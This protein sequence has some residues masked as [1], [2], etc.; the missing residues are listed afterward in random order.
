MGV[1]PAL[2][3]DVPLLRAG[4][5]WGS[6]LRDSE[7]ANS[8]MQ[9]LAQC[10]IELW[11]DGQNMHPKLLFQT[12]GTFVTLMARAKQV[13]DPPRWME[14]FH[15][16][17][18]RF[19]QL[20]QEWVKGHILEFMK[21]PAD[22]LKKARD[23]LAEASLPATFEHAGKMQNALEHIDAMKH[24][25]PVE[26][27]MVV[28]DLVKRLRQSITFR[29]VDWHLVAQAL[30]PD[31]LKIVQDYQRGVEENILHLADETR[32]GAKKAHEMVGKYRLGLGQRACSLLS[33]GVGLRFTTGSG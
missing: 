3:V 21:D 23:S 14:M 8:I 5:I 20:A 10:L 1:C 26:A 6:V 25:K 7:A 18:G 16:A 28:N 31:Q 2:F 22:G 30:P 32:K 17:A 19:N 9:S 15:P 33:S 27:T 11:K 29:S 12:E 13:K 24:L 4:A